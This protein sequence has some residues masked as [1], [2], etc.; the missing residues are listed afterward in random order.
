MS[1]RTSSIWPGS[2]YLLTPNPSIPRSDFLKVGP[3]KKTLFASVE[4]EEEEEKGWRDGLMGKVLVTQR[5]V[6][7]V[8]PDSHIEKQGGMHL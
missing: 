3:Q 5:E 8:M 1:S 7:E 2:S 4:E 6:Q